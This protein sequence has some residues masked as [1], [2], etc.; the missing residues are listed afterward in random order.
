MAEVRE[1]PR[2]ELGGDAA[3]LQLFRYV[4]LLP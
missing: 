2:H 3:R 1:L 4:T